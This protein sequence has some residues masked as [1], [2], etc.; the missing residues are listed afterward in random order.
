MFR[1]L[2]FD[3]D[4]RLRAPV[5]LAGVLSFFLFV[6]CESASG[7]HSQGDTHTR[8]NKVIELFDTGK[9][10]FGIFSYGRSMHNAIALGASRLDF[11]FPTETCANSCRTW[12]L[13]FGSIFWPHGIY[14]RRPRPPNRCGRC[15]EDGLRCRP[16]LIRRCCGGCGAYRELT[17]S[18]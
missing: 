18:E 10:A 3:N 14:R 11:I 13:E 6:H 4:Q 12:D 1:Q 17:S 16:C 9:P 8:L 7:D 5:C 2:C 15:L